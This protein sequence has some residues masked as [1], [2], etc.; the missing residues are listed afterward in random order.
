MDAVFPHN[1]EQRQKV[2]ARG[3]VEN[4]SAY[5][6]TLENSFAAYKD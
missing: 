2:F 4:Y 1:L 3:R 5:H 6:E